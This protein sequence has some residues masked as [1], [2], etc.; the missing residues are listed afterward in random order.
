MAFIKVLGIIPACGL[1]AVGTF[2]YATRQIEAIELS[3]EDP[4]FNGE[5]HRKYNPNNNPTV[6]D[7]HIRKIPISQ[8]DPAYLETPER[9]I[10]RFS[11]GVWAGSGTSIYFYPHVPR[12]R[13]DIKSN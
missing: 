3:P 7:L 11:G 13:T 10:E 6:N 5:Y 2:F 8:I 1:L 12:S 9:L 4:I